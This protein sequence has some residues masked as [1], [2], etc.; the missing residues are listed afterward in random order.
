MPKLQALNPADRDIRNG[1]AAAENLSRI[2][3]SK[4]KKPAE[5][6]PAK[7]E[8]E[9]KK[10]VFAK[11]DD[12]MPS[13]VTM[14]D[15]ERMEP[16]E[17]ETRLAETTKKTPRND[18]ADAHHSHLTGAFKAVEYS[19][20]EKK[21]N[22]RGSIQNK[23][24]DPEH[25]IGNIHKFKVA[26]SSNNEFSEPELS[27]EPEAAEETKAPKAAFLGYITTQETI[28]PGLSERTFDTIKPYSLSDLSLEISNGNGVRHMARR[29]GNLLMDEGFEKPHLTNA[30]HFNHSETKI[31]YCIGYLQEAYRVAQEIPGYQNMEKV[32]R[33]ERP[34]IKVKVLIGKDLI[35]FDDLFMNR[36]WNS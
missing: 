31:Y 22:L 10:D 18:K 12:E 23:E 25:K 17:I 5:T 36:Y 30:S 1:L 27:E 24:T 32:D 16:R 28:K 8:A 35:L 33:L 3:Q 11:Y 15:E 29:V 4:N 7:I 14:A 13:A 19:K 20:S 21:N 6:A 34:E 9:V 26:A 2:T